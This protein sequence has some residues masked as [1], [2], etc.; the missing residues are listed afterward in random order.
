MRMGE[1][2][3]NFVKSCRFMHARPLVW[4]CLSFIVGLLVS[5]MDTI[6]VY[7]WAVFA[8]CLLLSGMAWL[9]W[10]HTGLLCL[11]IVFFGIGLLRGLL[12][13]SYTIPT[14]P[15][16]SSLQ[17][18]VV[19]QV[20]ELDRGRLRITLEDVQVDGQ[21]LPY[22]TQLTILTRLDQ[23]PLA[24]D[25]IRCDSASI[26]IPEEDAFDGTYNAQLYL[27]SKGIYY[28][29]VAAQAEVTPSQPRLHHLPARMAA[30]L[31]QRIDAL[32]PLQSGTVTGMIMGDQSL[33]PDESLQAF[34]IS[35]VSHVLS[36]SGLHIGFISAMLLYVIRKPKRWWQILLVLL[37][38]WLY[39]AMVGLPASAVR[40]CCMST[41]ALLAQVRG[42]RYDLLTALAVSALVILFVAPAQLFAAG[43]LLS[44][45]AMLG[46]AALCGPLEKGLHFLPQWL[47]ASLS[48]S[49]S[50]QMG[51]W[52][53]GSYLFGTVQILSLIHIWA[54]RAA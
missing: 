45:G 54:Y 4:I 10:P 35:G 42:E 7:G 17:G 52:P 47:R 38:L 33:L 1:R 15:A 9:R 44:F 5:R 28:Q 16:R 26:E 12:A 40:A 11:S 2:C 24:G 37:S 34:R 6:P 13:F 29:A 48:L 36:V 20:T 41:L 3:I 32:Y 21:R 31:K 50:A 22:R 18:V 14:P 23:T 51:V 19:D 46:I 43:F 39:C 8:V 25:V 49:L 27:Q 53:I 30:W